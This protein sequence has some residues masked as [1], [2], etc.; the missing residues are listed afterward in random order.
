MSLFC[1]FVVASFALFFCVIFLHFLDKSVLMKKRFE[2]Y[3]KLKRQI[4]A[5]YDAQKAQ[6]DLRKALWRKLS[7]Y[8]IYESVILFDIRERVPSSKYGFWF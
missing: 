4:Y 1:L 8:G 2:D 5:E 7:R 3:A 6:S